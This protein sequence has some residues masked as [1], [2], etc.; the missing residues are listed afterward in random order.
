MPHFGLPFQP[1]LPEDHHVDVCPFSFEERERE[2]RALKEKRLEELR[3]EEVKCLSLSRR[4]SKAAS[5]HAALPPFQV[6]QFKAQPLPDFDSVV[7]PEKKKLEATKPEPFKLLIDER[8][9]VK[10]S[11]WEQMVPDLT[12][13]T[14]LFPLGLHVCLRLS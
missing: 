8:G 11:R 1:R 14:F 13:L 9:A 3:N 5:T 4:P 12:R 6:P 10:S 2:R 7:L